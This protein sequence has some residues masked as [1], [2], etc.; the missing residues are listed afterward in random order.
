MKNTAPAGQLTER[1]ISPDAALIFSPDIPTSISGKEGRR[2]NTHWDPPCLRRW[3]VIAF[4]VFYVAVIVAVQVIYSVSVNNNGIATTQSGRHYLWT[5]G[6]TAIFVVVTVCWRQVDYAAKSIQPWAEMAKGPQPA[7]NSLLLDYVTPF[8]VV[9]L[10]RSLRNGHFNVSCTIVLFFLLKVLT[11]VSTGI[12]SLQPVQTDD[13]SVNMTL[14]DT[15]DG[16][17]FQHAA[18]VDSRAAYIVYGHKEYNISLPVGT[19]DQYAAEIFAPAD[20]FING[21][22]TYSAQVNV[23]SASLSC[24]SGQLNHTT[25]YSLTSNA[26][27][28]SYYNTSVSLPDCEIYNAVM[29]APDWYYLQNDTQHRFGYRASF[30]NVSCSNLAEDDPQRNRFMVAVAYSEGFSQNNNSLLNSSNIVCIPSYSIQPATVILDTQGNVQAVHVAGNLRTIDGVSGVDIAAGV[31]A[32][33][34]QATSITISS[35]SDLV[36]DVFTTLM[37]QDSPIFNTEDLL[38]P[39]YLNSTANRVFGKVAAQIASLYLLLPDTPT[40]HS[41]VSGSV[42]RD[43]N[44]LLV[45]EIP[46]RIIQGLAGATLLLTLCVLL[47]TPRGVVPRSVDSIVAVAAILARSPGLEARLQGSGHKTLKELNETLSPYRFRTSAGYE[48]GVRVFSIQML[49]VAGLEAH[50]IVEGGHSITHNVSWTRP[51]M[52]RRIGIS[53]TI[54]ASIAAIVTL[55]VLLSQ[56]QNHNGLAT[57]NDAN[58]TR[59]SWLYVPVIVFVLLG[60]LFNLMDFEIELS[61]PFHALSR[62]DCE[63]SSMLWNPMRT[64]SLHATWNGLKHSRFALTAASLSAVLAPFLTIVVA[65]LFSVRADTQGT[66]VGVT[67]LNWFNTTTLNSPETNIPLLVIEGNMSYPQWTYDELAFPS[68][69]ASTDIGITQL[70]QGGSLSVDTPALRAATTCNAVPQERVLEATIQGNYLSTNISTPEGCG[71]SGLID[72]PY[73]FLTNNLAVPVNSSGYFGDTLTLGFSSGCPTIALFYGHVTTNELDNFTAVLCTQYIERVQA[74]VMFKLPDFSVSAEP[75]VHANSAVNFSS[76]YTSFPQLQVLNV[77]SADDNLD[78]IF[79]AMVFGKDGVPTAELLNSDTLIQSYTHLYRQYMAQVVNL[80]LRADFSTLSNNSTETV[81]NPLSGMYT[82][83]RHFRLVQ[84]P[85]S[86]HLLVG[87]L[88]ALLICALTIFITIDLRSGLPKPVGSVAAVASLLAGSRIVDP[89]SGLIPPG[90]EYWSDAEWEKSG[91]WQS[92][93]FRMG[94]WN[95]FNEPVESWSTKK[96]SSML[97]GTLADQVASDA[98]LNKSFRIDARPKTST[99]A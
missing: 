59:Y 10:W 64:I 91:V 18:A 83:P 16:S 51:F 72:Q 13:L 4:V 96:G 68:L 60:T 20:G 74:D 14:N 8:Q 26:P 1:E 53:L 19:T 23:F 21:S 7:Q 48:D 43:E 82:N 76:W 9:S 2:L 6:P 39:D 24:E 62:A 73:F 77:T 38:D 63:S 56:S 22:L 70:S 93:M 27:V 33:S 12:F 57:V 54:L 40:S 65:G 44:R 45:R 42:S 11:V 61:E 25:A 29:D 81:A 32:T 89:K 84:S 35:S 15:F 95:K 28:S 47:I 85:L 69:D 88:A 3:V 67:A 66:S 98:S 17:S 55:E 5:Y 87:V 37:Q 97:V 75:V 86:T 79:S 50:E 34:E 71:N 41:G 52:L 99:S 90:S 80:Y 36:L 46:V 94:Y 49:P 92:E 58:M 78:K 31:Q 30:Q